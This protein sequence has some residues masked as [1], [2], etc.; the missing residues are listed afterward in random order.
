MIIDVNAYLGPFAFRQLRHNTADGLLRLMDAKGIDKACVSS[1]ASITYR[2]TQSGNEEVAEAVKPHRDRLIPLAVI[3]P[4]YAGWRDDLEACHKD[5]GMKGLRLYPKWHNYSLAAPCCLDLIDAAAERGMFISIP[6]RAEDE[7]QRSWLVDVQDVTAAEIVPLVKARPEAKFLLL[8]GIGYSRSPLGTPRSGLPANYWI[9][10]SRLSAVMDNEIGK[11]VGV[12]GAD[13][14]V[15][16]TGMPFN[17]P[18]P[19]LVKMEV[20]GLTEADK[21]KIF[22]T[23]AARLLGLP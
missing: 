9:E 6:F 19:S 14:V 4:G 21:E 18:D 20:A 10:I 7:R 15:F 8:N 1:A 11:L 17:S 23:N 2:N 3:N 13:R 22:A 12:L 16:G 5:F